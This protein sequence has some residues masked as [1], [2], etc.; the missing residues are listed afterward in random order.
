ML[1]DIVMKPCDRTRV[2]TAMTAESNY[3]G[4]AMDRISEKLPSVFNKN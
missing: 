2:T 1:N 4:A 3:T